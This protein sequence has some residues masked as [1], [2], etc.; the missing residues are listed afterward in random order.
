MPPCY[1]NPMRSLILILILATYSVA[2]GAPYD[3]CRLVHY[4]VKGRYLLQEPRIGTKRAQGIL[5]YAHG[6]G[7][8]EEQGMNPS[9]YEGTF[10][11]LRTLLALR[12]FIYICPRLA[13][14]NTLYPHLRKCYGKLPLYLAGA[15]AGG[16]TVFSEM[17]NGGRKYEGV[18]LLCPA[19]CPP[20]DITTLPAKLPPLYF[21]SGEADLF[22]TKFCRNLVTALK[23][24]PNCQF[25]YVEIKGGNHDA[26]VKKVNWRKA[27]TF[28]QS[29]T[30]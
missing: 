22:I 9:H 10:H 28:L 11:R 13:D 18:I 2:Q 29:L 4:G 26:P 3:K 27:L 14:F 6:G 5:I 25:E 7:G 23:K 8:L 30:S 21:V 24:R 1:F 17:V 15:S 19:L 16:A 12:N 20:F